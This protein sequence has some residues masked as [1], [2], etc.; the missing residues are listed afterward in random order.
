MNRLEIDTAGVYKITCTRTGK[1]YI[2]SS[3]NMKKRTNS[4]R[5]LL[6]K[7]THTSIH[8]QR[9]WKKHGAE[10]FKVEVLFRCSVDDL[11]FYEQRALNT[12]KPIFNIL[13]TAGSNRG[14]IVSAATREKQSQAVK[15][16]LKNTS[17]D[18][19]AHIDRLLSHRNNPKRLANLR[20]KLVGR[21]NIF[22]TEK[23]IQRMKVTK[24]ATLRKYIVCG[25]ALCLP[26]IREKY[27]ISAYAF[28]NRIN[29][30]WDN[31]RAALAPL[32]EQMTLS[33]KGEKISKRRLCRLAGCSDKTMR[34]LL[35]EGMSADEIIDSRTKTG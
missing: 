20:A 25:E 23:S 14:F 19:K 34:K 31:D 13:P 28:R 3:Y 10:H 15:E 17:Y 1:F 21:P 8:L 6:Q 30:G 32:R 22:V 35:A 26:E 2:G 27:G 12:L 29:A 9:A 5:C 18:R 33:H 11:L 16:R 24:R 4:H 7:N